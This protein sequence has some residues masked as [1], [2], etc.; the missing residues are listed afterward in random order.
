MHEIKLIKICGKMVEAIVNDITVTD[1]ISAG[2]INVSK[3]FI[4]NKYKMY[5]VDETLL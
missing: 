2:R 3:K 4:G 1:G 5:L